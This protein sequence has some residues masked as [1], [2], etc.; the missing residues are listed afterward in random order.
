[1]VPTRRQPLAYLLPMLL[2]T[3]PL[4]AGLY[5]LERSA[6][7]RQFL[8]ERHQAD[9]QR[10]TDRCNL[11]G[12]YLTITDR[13][14]LDDAFSR[15]VAGKRVY[16][17]GGCTLEAALDTRSLPAPRSELG[18]YTLPNCNFEGLDMVTRWL[19]SDLGLGQRL[20]PDTLVLVG[21]ATD[22]VEPERSP[23]TMDHFVES[24]LYEYDA[25]GIRLKPMA[26]L[27]RSF[28]L[29][30]Q[31]LAHMLFSLY[32]AR[33]HHTVLHPPTGD[34]RDL[35]TRDLACQLEALQRIL[36]R[37]K[38]TGATVQAVYMP[39]GSWHE[40]PAW[41]RVRTEIVALCRA[42]GVPVLDLTGLLKDRDFL[43]GVDHLAYTGQQKTNRLLAPVVR[44]YLDEQAGYSDCRTADRQQ[45]G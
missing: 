31:R 1:M 45:S 4:V 3:V 11:A 6:W 9:W 5:R 2:L 37:M 42:E 40:T 7:I 14:L 18:I 26:G 16:L 30:R 25:A 13:V 15:T 27:A 35:D 10:Q 19:T 38:K 22:L 39:N 43:D 33:P 32:Q 23:G 36:D 21:L 29:A 8:F 20:G 41:A 24:G 12:P 17:F 34:R 44:P 28:S